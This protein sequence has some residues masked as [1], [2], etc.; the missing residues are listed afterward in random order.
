MDSMQGKRC[1]A[2]FI[3]ALFPFS[4]SLSQS[5]VLKVG[6][7]SGAPGSSGNIVSI[8]LQNNVAVAGLQLTL[9]Y[10][11]GKLTAK[12]VASTAR[13]SQMA[14]FT[15]NEPTSGELRL[16][17]SDL[18]GKVISSGNGSIADVYFD[19][20]ANASPGNV[21]LILSNVVM[22][23][24]NAQSIPVTTE[25][26]IFTITGQTGT[27]QITITIDMQSEIQAGRF[28]P[29]KGE[30][31]VIGDYNN[32]TIGDTKLLRLSNTTTYS[33]T[34][35]G[36]NASV[37]DT[38]FFKFAYSNETKII[39][40]GIPTLRVPIGNHLSMNAGWSCNLC[41]SSSNWANQYSSPIRY[42]IY[43]SSNIQIPTTAFYIPESITLVS[44]Q[45]R[46]TISN[47]KP[48]FKWNPTQ[49]T[50]KYRLY[51]YDAND[52]SIINEFATNTE[53]TPQNPLIEITYKWYI[54]DYNSYGVLRSSS[55]MWYFNIS[56][57]T[58]VSARDQNLPESFGLSPNYP[59]P[60]NPETIIR[61]QLP[62]S[63]EVELIMYNTLGQK[64]RTIVNEKQFPGYYEVIWDGRNDSGEQVPSGV[65]IYQLKAGEFVDAR[66]LLLIR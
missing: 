8:L 20:K 33:V 51:V 13:S 10:D 7:G 57:P 11:S 5:N 38:I 55:E 63:S 41:H 42:F 66:K 56:N 37:G 24:A 23:D 32:W 35:S 26:G 25:N 29:D 12:N 17:V 53:F 14:I 50:A 48:K 19:V 9:S 30:V 39:A 52:R 21:N 62:N 34:L 3:L 44:P 22:S 47:N 61:Y 65:Y 43:N 40:E 60:F 28:N 46:S 64:I 18:S 36:L 49:N 1:L 15:F 31:M 58:F 6:S 45:D 16:I 59:N 54:V 4:Q 27:G 2:T